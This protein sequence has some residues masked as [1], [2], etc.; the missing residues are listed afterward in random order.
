[1]SLGN[2]MIKKHGTRPSFLLSL[3]GPLVRLVGSTGR[4]EKV[5]C[6]LNAAILLLFLFNRIDRNQKQGK[7]LDPYTVGVGFVLFF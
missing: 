3:F 4:L 2:Y 5:R 6:P 1:M 7:A